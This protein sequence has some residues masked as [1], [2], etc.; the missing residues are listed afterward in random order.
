MRQKA[1]V[2]HSTLSSA[3]RISV[4]VLHR[5]TV[6]YIEVKYKFCVTAPS[7]RNGTLT[8]TQ[9]ITETFRTASAV[10]PNVPFPQAPLRRSRR[11]NSALSCYRYRR[12]RPPFAVSPER[13]PSRNVRDEMMPA[14]ARAPLF[15][16]PHRAGEHHREISD[17]LGDSATF[18]RR[19]T[20][21]ST[22]LCRHFSHPSCPR[23][24]L[25][26]RWERW[27]SALLWY[28]SL[29]GR[30]YAPCIAL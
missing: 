3:R 15:R 28:I 8:I 21:S 26:P 12:L 4:R 23:P 19:S 30:S 22:H 18:S 5:P 16:P 29:P 2:A 13:Y 6:F 20:S 9:P 11:R 25:T 10:K 7:Q 1:S 17:K 24:I 27:P 14:R